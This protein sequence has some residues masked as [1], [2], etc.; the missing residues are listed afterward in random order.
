MKY[1]L[2]SL[3]ALL[4]TI[5][6]SCIANGNPLVS[7]ENE[8]V[9]IFPD[10]VHVEYDFKNNTH[11][12]LTHSLEFNLAFYNYDPSSKCPDMDRRSSHFNLV[13][14]GKVVNPIV[15][16][17]A[18]LPLTDGNYKDVTPVLRNLGFN[19]DEISNYRNYEVSCENDMPIPQGKYE[20]NLKKLIKNGLAQEEDFHPVWE[21][22][23]VYSLKQEFKA[24]E[25]IHV[26]YEY[27]PTVGDSNNNLGSGPFTL[28]GNSIISGIKDLDKDDTRCV[29]LGEPIDT[30]KALQDQSKFTFR[31]IFHNVTSDAAR[32]GAV[33]D[34][35]LKVKKVKQRN[36]M[37]ICFDSKVSND[38]GGTL[39]SHIKNYLPSKDIIADY[40]YQSN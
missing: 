36:N 30:K 9:T 2:L 26:V 1:V 8:V 35:T 16:F 19:D 31:S 33:K 6:A 39:S 29:M 13:V 25:V 23:E 11:T 17:K 4:N 3:F 12:T 38:D 15:S 18:R 37:A 34:F 7:I 14:K 10:L 24:D 32:Y 28:K 20:A 22:S 27:A 5:A 21:T 40:L